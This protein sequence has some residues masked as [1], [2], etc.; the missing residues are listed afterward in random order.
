MYL[1][2]KNS[3]I[4]LKKYYYFLNISHANWQTCEPTLMQSGL[5][6]SYTERIKIKCGTTYAE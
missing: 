6:K 4:L 1:N 3:K 5:Q 2:N